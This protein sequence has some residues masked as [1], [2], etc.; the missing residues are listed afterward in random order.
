[1]QA[2]LEGIAVDRWQAMRIF[3]RTADCGSF[4][5]AARQLNMSSPAVTRAVAALED[6]IGTR[7]LTDHALGE[8]H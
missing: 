5:G 2:H 8:A 6:V 1:L 7:L 3:M 4:T